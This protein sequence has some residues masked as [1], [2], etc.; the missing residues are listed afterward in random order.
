MVHV[1][2]PPDL[3]VSAGLFMSVT[4]ADNAGQPSLAARIT[5]GWTVLAVA[6]VVLVWALSHVLLIIFFAI[7][8]ALVLRGAA[9]WLA[10][11][12]HAS[13]GLMLS[14]V[15]LTLV[16]AG[17]GLVYWIG[18]RLIAQG[19][20]LA[21]RLSGQL[22]ILQ[23]HFDNSA[24]GQHLAAPLSSVGQHVFG[25]AT[26]AVGIGLTTVTDVVVIVVTTLYLAAHPSLYVRGVLRLFPPRRRDRILDVMHEIAH[27]L[28]LWVLGQLIDMV[29]V[30]TL[31]AAGLSL[32][33]VPAP[34]ALAV[35]T[36][37]LTF[38]P[39]LGAIAAGVP[40]VLVALTV[41]WT[42]VLWTLLIYTGCHVV[43]G[44]LVAPLVQR[45][46]INLPPALTILGMTI[47]GALFG[48][49]GVIL[50]TPLAA[51]GLVIVRELYVKDTLGDE[52]EPAAQ[53]PRLWK[54]RIMKPK[55][56]RSLEA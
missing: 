39:Y 51:A 28:R 35:L 20:D 22:E 37:L 10:E 6:L 13:P 33:G 7:L 44:Y 18:P 40:A 24:I 53:A 55:A 32:L 41:G 48:I 16:L 42:P 3:I 29:T 27:V 38:I 43:E 45:R 1:R 21:A 34:Y 54:R 14:A 15:A 56:V 47:T 31:S 5:V 2:W 25:T 26:A 52:E 11:R 12:L 19:Q 17:A 36:G 23:R 8:L 50:G 49:L 30:G 9:T 4:Q 46:L